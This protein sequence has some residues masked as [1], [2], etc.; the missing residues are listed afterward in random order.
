[1]EWESPVRVVE[2]QIG[3]I[4]GK[5]LQRGRKNVSFTYNSLERRMKRENCYDL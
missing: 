4:Q 5:T 2:D 1:M 3:R